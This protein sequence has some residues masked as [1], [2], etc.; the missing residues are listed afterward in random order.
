MSTTRLTKE[1]YILNRD[2]KDEFS[3]SPSKD[4]PL[5]WIVKI[6]GPDDSPYQR[7]IFFILIRF[8]TDYPFKPPTV[9][10]TTK[11]YH[12]NIS[13]DGRIFVDMLDSR[14]SPAFTIDKVLMSINILLCEPNTD[15]P[16]EPEIAHV[17]KTDRAKYNRLAAEW[18]RKYAI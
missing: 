7:G 5:R 3:I 16:V 4:D 8:P 13:R 14:W 12:P 15:D 6:K 1:L 17:Y 9:S 18:T 10:F 11:I 2:H